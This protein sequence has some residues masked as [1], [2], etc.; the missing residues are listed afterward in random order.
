MI[1]TVYLANPSWVVADDKL[2]V[3]TGQ[4][5]GRTTYVGDVVDVTGSTVTFKVKP[6]GKVKQ[7]PRDDVVEILTLF[8]ESHDRG[9]AALS[10]S[11][12]AAALPELEKGLRDE[13]RTWVQREI[14]Q[15]LIRCDLARG[16]RLTAARR[17]L[18]ITQ[19]DPETRAFQL[20][21]LAWNADLPPDNVLEESRRWLGQKDPVAQLLGAS[22]LLT[23]P[24]D[25]PQ[26]LKTLHAL[27]GVGQVSVQRLAMMQLWRQRVA[28]DEYTDDDLR[29]WEHWLDTEAA[30]VRSGAFYVIGSAHRQRL[31]HERAAAAFLWLPL[32]Y[33]ADAWLA[34]EA[35]LEAA[36]CLT[37]MGD[38]AG[39]ARLRDEIR[40]RYPEA[41]ATRRLPNPNTTA[42]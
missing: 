17:F 33:D 37:R 7:F 11:D 24:T 1:A 32:V 16:D 19:S 42:P 6:S 4:T 10:R 9:Q 21:P 15:S 38:H 29:R 40:Q 8:S 12:Y 20:I 41:P 26:A 27:S 13:P 25:R 35:G 5:S 30:Q 28:D 22:F 39:A 31:D 18:R 2:V 36:N 14:L 34:A 23:S 3:R